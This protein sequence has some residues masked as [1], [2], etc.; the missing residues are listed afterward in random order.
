MLLKANSIFNVL[1]HK[2]Q[3]ATDQCTQSSE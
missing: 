1:P 3:I 2:M